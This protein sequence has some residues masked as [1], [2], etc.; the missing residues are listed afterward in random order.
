MLKIFIFFRVEQ[1]LDDLRNRVKRLEL[2]GKKDEAKLIQS[3]IDEL[4]RQVNMLYG[5]CLQDHDFVCY[6]IE[7]KYRIY[8]KSLS[9]LT[10][11]CWLFFNEP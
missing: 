7:C 6:L 5:V 9:L 4:E 10:S 11:Y 1:Q 8:Y 3:E 2:E